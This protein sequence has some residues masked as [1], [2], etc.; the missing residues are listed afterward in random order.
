MTLDVLSKD[1]DAAMD[2]VMDVLTEPAGFEAVRDALKAGGFE[3]EVAEVTQRA[4][5]S[6]ELGAKEAASMIKLL[7][8]LED[9]DDVQNVY[10]NAEIPDAVLATL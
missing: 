3:P 5:V 2:L 7:E 8:M 9:L 1:L 6:A 10:S 4:S